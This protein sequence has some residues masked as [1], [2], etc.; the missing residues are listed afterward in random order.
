M[1][2]DLKDIRFAVFVGCLVLSGLLAS[3][4]WFFDAVYFGPN[5]E[6]FYSI[7]LGGNLTYQ[8][9]DLTLVIGNN[10]Q[11]T[12]RPLSIFGISNQASWEIFSSLLSGEYE[13]Y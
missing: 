8:D 5:A 13:R 10:R 1:K 12:T 7:R 6:K 4:Y 2:F 11:D 3:F 9:G